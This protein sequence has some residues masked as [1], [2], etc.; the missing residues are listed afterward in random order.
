MNYE[1]CSL[2]M[3]TIRDYEIRDV[4]VSGGD[5]DVSIPKTRN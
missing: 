2:I 5:G 3:K 4:E 1:K